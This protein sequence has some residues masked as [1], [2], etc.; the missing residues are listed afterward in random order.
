MI[1]FFSGSGTLYPK[2]FSGDSQVSRDMLRLSPHLSTYDR[3]MHPWVCKQ[4]R[5]LLLDRRISACDVRIMIDA[6]VKAP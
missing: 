6:L 3:R 4:P 5:L 1:R 2:L